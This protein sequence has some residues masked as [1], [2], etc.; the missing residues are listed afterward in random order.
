MFVNAVCKVDFLFL[1]FV[2]DRVM[3]KCHECDIEGLHA[4]GLIMMKL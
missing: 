3:R 2:E 4:V 1:I